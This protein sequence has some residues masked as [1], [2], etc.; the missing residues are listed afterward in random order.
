MASPAD[1]LRAAFAEGDFDGARRVLKGMDPEV[2]KTRGVQDAIAYGAE[3]SDRVGSKEGMSVGELKRRFQKAAKEITEESDK[4][5]TEKQRKARVVAEELPD[6]VKKAAADVRNGTTT[7]K[8]D[9]IPRGGTTRTA[10]R[11]V[12][13]RTAKAGKTGQTGQTGST[14]AAAKA[15]ATQTSPPAASQSPANGSGNTKGAERGVRGTGGQPAG[16]GGSRL[17]TS[18]V[19]GRVAALGGLNPA[20]AKA[21]PG[22]LGVSRAASSAAKISPAAQAMVDS[23]AAQAT[24]QGGLIVP[25]ARNTRAP[26]SMIPGMGAVAGGGAPP[27]NPPG[28]PLGPV[29]GPPPPML[30]PSGAELGRA[31]SMNLLNGVTGAPSSNNLA[32]ARLAASASADQMKAMGIAPAVI[33]EADRGGAALGTGILAQADTIGNNVRARPRAAIPGL[34]AFVDPRYL[35]PDTGVLQ[36]TGQRLK[37]AGGVKGIGLRGLGYYTA[38]EAANQLAI[39]PIAKKTGMDP[40]I[41]GGLKGA[42][43]GAALGAAVGAPFAGVGAAPGAAVGAG[44]GALVGVLRGGGGGSKGDFDTASIMALPGLPDSEKRNLANLYT[45]MV[46]MGTPAKEAQAAIRQKALDRYVSYQEEEAQYARVVPNIMALQGMAAT[47]AQPYY[48]DFTAANDQQRAMADSMT[49]ML[50]ENQRV[51][52]N[53]YA[54]QQQAQG[55]TT[56]AAFANSNLLAPAFYLQDA[57]KQ[58]AYS[59]GTP[60]LGGMGLSGA[61]GVQGGA[62]AIDANVLKQIQG[63]GK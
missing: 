17:L 40:A 53:A 35:D 39:D 10:R 8:K 22:V 7:K 34:G 12:A 20:A 21:S 2:A 37:T 16:P 42:T 14:S 19:Q 5:K 46:Q 54:A 61:L 43:T 18:Q 56:A 26:S 23:M 6:D 27:L 57:L 55:Q 44:L 29:Q 1:K 47:F 52:A 48:K 58:N 41:S 59:S 31:A 13:A 60:P 49:A 62:P 45:M 24:T 38:A 28:P 9:T 63:V 4:V 36:S 3:L 25:P 33:G 32:A 50:P 15:P 51:S 30:G 11:K